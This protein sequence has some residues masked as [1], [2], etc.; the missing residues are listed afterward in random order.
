MRSSRKRAIDEVDGDDS[1]PHKEPSLLQSI[2]NMWQLANVVQFLTIFG[3][4]LKID[5][6]DINVR[7]TRP[8]ALS[9][10]SHAGCADAVFTT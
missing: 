10:E 1:L 8:A 7:H 9:S 2:R 3:P 5:A 4:A 6:P